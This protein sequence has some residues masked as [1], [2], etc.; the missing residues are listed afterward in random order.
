ME[1][2][3]S[4]KQYNNNDVPLCLKLCDTCLGRGIF[5]IVRRKFLLPEISVSE[6]QA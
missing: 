4:L 1:K 3:F 2:A 5:A 6:E